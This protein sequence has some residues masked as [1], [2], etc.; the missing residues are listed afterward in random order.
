MNQLKNARVQYEKKWMLTGVAMER[1]PVL[2]P[3]NH[4]TEVVS[5]KITA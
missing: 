1:S 2:Y 3:E 5:R 4:K